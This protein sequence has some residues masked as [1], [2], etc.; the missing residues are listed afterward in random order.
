MAEREFNLLDEPWIVALKP[1]GTTEKVSLVDALDRAGEFRGLAGELPTQDA[2]VL[3]L[4]LAVLHTVISRY[5]CDGEEA[6]LESPSQAVRRWKQIWAAKNFPM[7]VVRAYLAQYHDRFWLFDPERP[8]YQVPGIGKGTS[9][10]AAKLNG[11]L[12]ESNNKL[13]LFPQRSGREKAA[14]SYD[15]AARWLLHVNA[16]DD[17]SGKK[18]DPQIKETPGAGWLGKLGVVMAEG[19]TLFETLMLNL[20]LLQDGESKLWEEEE[21]PIWERES[22]DR[23]ERVRIEMPG[24]LSGLYTLQ[25]RRIELKREGGKV[26]GYTLLGGEFFEKDN[27]FAEQMTL[28]HNS[29]KNDKSAPLHQP[30]RH[31]PARQLWRDFAPLVSQREGS[32]RP[33]VVS[34]ISCLARR[35]ALPTGL[36]RFRTVSVKYADKD[37]FI[38]DVFSD[39]MAF[40]GAMLTETGEAWIAKVIEQIETADALVSQLAS[41]AQGI[42]KAL[43]DA[44][45]V[46]ARNAAR[47]TAYFRLDLPF[48]EWLEGIDAETDDQAEAAARWWKTAQG[49]IRSIGREMV[50]AAGP[51]ALVGRTEQ[52]KDKQGKETGKKRVYCAPNAYNYFLYRTASRQALTTGG[53]QNG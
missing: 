13:R 32:R 12:S 45:G 35:G 15:E 34:W 47:E 6:P 52:E 20:I 14:L 4:L 23:R 19:D 24:N 21:C 10:S 39:S 43:G 16:F 48:R 7:E 49:I 22:V 38:D 29:A 1:N 36:I 11:E 27:A 46:D 31:A 26:V 25:S 18:T 28:W 3:R 33:G 40:S 37:F 44:D 8:F 2:A 50:A 9:Y 53:K 42:A 17:T 51:K 41:L 30:R 5:D